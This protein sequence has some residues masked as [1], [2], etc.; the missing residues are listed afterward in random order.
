MKLTDIIPGTKFEIE[1][2]DSFGER[3]EFILI[4]QLEW[5]K[6]ENTLIIDAPLKEGVVFPIRIGSNINIYYNVKVGSNNYNLYTFS[7]V[8]IDR[9]LH[10]GIAMLA[11]QKISDII[12]IQ[13]RNY[14]RFEYSMPIEYKML[15]QNEIE[16]ESDYILTI[17]RDLSGEGVCF[18]SEERLNL[19]DVVE[20]ILELNENKAI[21]K[22]KIVRVSKCSNEGKFNYE[23]GVN[24]INITDPER[25][26]MIKF[27]FGTQSKLRKKGLI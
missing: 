19:G 3:Y 21:F 10:D 23:N 26:R 1:T 17:I 7:S 6:D 2:F 8:V 13:R 22:G 25:E 9:K 5:V 15:I 27:I 24:I 12:K 11:I 18:M 14:F 16:V 20:F 4:S